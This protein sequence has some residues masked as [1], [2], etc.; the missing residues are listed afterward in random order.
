[1]ANYNIINGDQLMAVYYEIRRKMKALHEIEDVK[2]YN[3]CNMK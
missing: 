1:M 3:V 2:K